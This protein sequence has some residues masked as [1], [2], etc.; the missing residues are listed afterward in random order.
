MKY[1]DN[2]RLKTAAALL[3]ILGSSASFAEEP[4][5]PAVP[6]LA[7]ILDA[8]GIAINGYVDTSY[9]YLSGLG[10]FSS[11][12][13]DRVFDARHNSFT[14]NQAAL[15]I[16]KQPKE[17]FGAVVNLTAGQ[18]AQVVESYPNTGQS[19]FDVTQAYV[20]YATGSWTVIGGKFV[21][22]AGAETINPTTD[23]N[24]S[25]SILFGYAIPFTHTGF[26]VTYG[27]ND[28]LNLI[29][30]LNNGWDQI[31]DPNSQKTVEFGAIYTP[32]KTFSLTVDGYV[33]T[34]PVSIVNNVASTDSGQRVL[35]DVVANWAITDQLSV[36]GN[37]DYGQQKDNAAGALTD[38]YEWSG[39]ALYLNYALNDQWS[40]SLRGEIFDDKNGYRTGVNAGGDGQKW[41]EVTLTLGYAPT[42]SFLMR[43]EG[44]YDKSNVADAFV[45]SVN[46][47]T[48]TTDYNDSQYSFA[49]EA[50]Y[51]F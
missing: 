2:R 19:N 39:G 8:S 14:L 50:I 6:A 11:G 5:K 3:G 46:N 12:T 49:V 45:E 18:D 28:Q 10:Y 34:E 30:G 33:G 1:D 23:T 7:D 31:S 27:L 36:I 29:L 40:A 21:T 25:R 15:T 41:K 16:A 38:K 51:K 17:G 32:V 24:F 4:A 48:E 44:R 20:Q 26:R 42:K 9:Q 22:L 47:A 13:P 43:F 35:I 37:F